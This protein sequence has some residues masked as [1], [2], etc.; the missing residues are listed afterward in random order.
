[1]IQIFVDYT[2]SSYCKILA[3]FL[4]SNSLSLYFINF[5]LS[6]VVLNLLSLFCPSPFPSPPR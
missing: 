6:I 5:I 1:M 2:P 4:C 3:I